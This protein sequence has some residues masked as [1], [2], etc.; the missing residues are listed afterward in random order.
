MAGGFDLTHGKAAKTRSS[1]GR[2]SRGQLAPGTNRT[3]FATPEFGNE[4]GTSGTLG[5]GLSPQPNPSDATISN[6][7]RQFRHMVFSTRK[8]RGQ[9]P[10]AVQQSGHSNSALPKARLASAPATRKRRRVHL[11][12]RRTGR[13]H[14]PIRPPLDCSRDQLVMAE[15][16]DHGIIGN[17]TLLFGFSDSGESPQPRRLPPPWPLD[18]DPHSRTSD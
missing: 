15:P 4:V 11:R 12:L 7:N 17:Q 3:I 8:T 14:N 13:S 18:T 10:R 9:L 6:T 16:L 2:Q 1:L 5:G